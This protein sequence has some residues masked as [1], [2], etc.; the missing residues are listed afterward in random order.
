M[1]IEYT[2][3]NFAVYGDQLAIL[4]AGRHG[5]PGAYH[6]Y[7]EYREFCDVDA[8][9]DGYSTSFDPDYHDFCPD[10]DDTNPDVNPGVPESCGEGSGCMPPTGNGIDDN[11]D[12]NVDEGC[13]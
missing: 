1:G 2:E 7:I 10:C 8:D 5:D 13:S 3:D 6:L 11:C 4:V 12:G 9:G